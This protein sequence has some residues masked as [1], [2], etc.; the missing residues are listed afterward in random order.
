MALKEMNKAMAKKLG[1]SDVIKAAIPAGFGVL[2]YSSNRD[3]GRGRIESAARVSAEAM[4]MNLI[5]PG[6]YLAGL[7]L[8]KVPKAAIEGYEKLD[9]RA[10][11]INQSGRVA[12]FQGNTFVDN[13]QIFTMRQAAVATMQQS[14]YSLEHAMQGN[15]ASF[16][17]R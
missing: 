12:P 10:R 2:N 14:K 8:A 9:Q 15:E 7:G 3:E 16:M 17:H 1:K 11:A 6:L 13:K 4:A 5:G